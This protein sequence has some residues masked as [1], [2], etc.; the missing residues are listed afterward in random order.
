MRKTSAVLAT[1]SLAVL[2]L[3]GCASAPSFA[4]DVC[5]R[6]AAST[7][8]VKDSV[9]V[10]GELG[11]APDVTVYSPVKPDETAFADIV[12][13]DG[14]AITTTGQTFV[15][16]FTFYAAESGEKLTASAY[17]GDLSRINNI[18]SWQTQV[19]GFGKVLECATAGTRMVAVLS[20]EDF[21]EGNAQSFGLGENEGVVG[22]VDVHA[23]DL[24]RATGALQFND[25]KGLPTVVRASDGTPGIIIPDS[26]APSEAVTQTLIKGEG[27]KVEEGQTLIMN[28]TT[29][30]WDDKKLISTTWGS[31]P[32]VAAAAPGL[33][34]ATIGSQL[35]VVTPEQDGA[36]ASA[37][38]I[39]ILGVVPVPEQ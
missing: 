34:G 39:D 8:S 27:A 20:A 3:T 37:T 12:T 22:V 13:G 30:G 29:V 10:E 21:G 7:A 24:A 28:S 14:R 18:T 25:A 38:V 16:D 36:P 26:A 35:L 6:A 9:T 15:I 31:D 1:L 32:Q 17:D 19:P 4:G 2:T 33:F 23:V 11:E 5:D